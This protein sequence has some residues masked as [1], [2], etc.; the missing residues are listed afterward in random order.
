MSGAQQFSPRVGDDVDRN[1]TDSASARLLDAEDVRRPQQAKRSP[2]RTGIVVGLAVSAL[3]VFGLTLIRGIG[4]GEAV[5]VSL[6]VGG[7]V[8]VGWRR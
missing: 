3:G 1:R 7:I 6:I 5:I 2:R 4:V 8:A